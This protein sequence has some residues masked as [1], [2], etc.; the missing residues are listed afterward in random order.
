MK[1]NIHPEGTE[2]IFE[3]M[4]CG[5]RKKIWS[6]VKTPHKIEIDGVIYPHVKLDNSIASYQ[7][8]KTV[9]SSVSRAKNFMDKFESFLSHIDNA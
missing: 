8:K 2:V 9:S 3:D 4:S 5:F 7:T 1:E 6:T